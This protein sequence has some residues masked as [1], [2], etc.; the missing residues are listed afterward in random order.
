[1]YI[2]YAN[3]LFYFR[4]YFNNKKASF[5]MTT[6]TNGAVHPLLFKAVET[7]NHLKNRAT[8]EKPYE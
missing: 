6:W 3:H 5:K 2:E 8:S 7:V 1:M 4:T